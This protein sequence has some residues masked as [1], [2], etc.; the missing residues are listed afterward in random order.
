MHV[1]KVDAACKINGLN[2]TIV[3]GDIIQQDVHAIVNVVGESG[4]LGMDAITL[5][6]LRIFRCL[7]CFFL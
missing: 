7:C 1:T 4:A 2:V 5:I 3:H 6:N